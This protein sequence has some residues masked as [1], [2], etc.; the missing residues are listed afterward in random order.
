MLEFA[1]SGGA[2]PSVVLQDVE[3][4]RDMSGGVRERKRMKERE[5]GMCIR[6]KQANQ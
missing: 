5:M 2:Q 4:A 3:G 6:N 1:C